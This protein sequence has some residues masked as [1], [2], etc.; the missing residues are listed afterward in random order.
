MPRSS[1]R[2]S[3]N[4]PSNSSKSDFDRRNEIISLARYGKITPEEAEAEA[5]ANGWKPFATQPSMPEFDPMRESRWTITMAIAWIAWRDESRVRQNSLRFSAECWHWIWREW[6]EA[7][8]GREE[9]APRQGWF[10]EQWSEPTAFRLR[11]EELW[12][13][14]ANALP[15][16]T[17]LSILEAER[18]LWEALMDERLVAE[19]LDSTGLPVQIPAGQWPYLQ[20]FED[21]KRDVVKYDALDRVPPYTEVKLKRVDLLQLWPVVSQYVGV[22]PQGSVEPRYI[23]GL[24]T[25]DRQGYVP[26]C[27]T[28]LWIMT[29]SGLHRVA[30]DD[31]G[32]WQAAVTELMP[33]LASDEIELIGL[34]RN[35]GLAEKISGRALAMVKVIPLLQA[36][37]RDYALEAPS[38]IDCSPFYDSESWARGLNDKLYL[39]GRAGA[40][41]THLQ[42]RKSQVLDHWPRPTPK[43]RAQSMCFRWLLQQMER[44]PAVRQKSKATY[45]EEARAQFVMSHRQ[46]LRAWDAAIAESG[47]EAWAKAG[48]T[49][50]KSNQRT[51]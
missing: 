51:K 11:I 50:T 28:L 29:K 8:N 24:A 27:V 14:R 6:N 30:I 19:A 9:L 44:S 37:P 35:G 25:G 2:T 49:P 40:E 22:K 42:A 7:S 33:F 21:G 23:D 20:L 46:F 48:R 3:S 5:A 4:P 1:A 39:T 17:Q 43:A 13:K 47:A 45:W 31:L 16:T 32:A 36:Q 26:L 12:L 38:H 34:P 41:W 10:L 15:S 18:G